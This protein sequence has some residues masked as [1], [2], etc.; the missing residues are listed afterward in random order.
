[1]TTARKAMKVGIAATPI[2]VASIAKPTPSEM[3]AGNNERAR[4]YNSAR[5]RKRR[6][7][8]LREHPLCKPCEDR[9]LVI[10][11]TV[12]DHV[13]GHQHAGWRDRFWDEARWQPL[14]A[15]CHAAKS[16]AELA[17]W[18]RTGQA[19]VEPGRGSRQK[20]EGRTHTACPPSKEFPA[21][22][23]KKNRSAPTVAAR[24]VATS[25]PA[26]RKKSAL[27]APPHLTAD[28]RKIW[29]QVVAHLEASG[30]AAA[31]IGP[32]VETYV[33]AVIRQRR[34]SAALA[35]A[36]LIDGDGKLHAA[37]RVLEATSA[38]VKN[39]AVT[40]G[41]ATPPKTRSAAPE[42]PREGKWAGVL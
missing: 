41:L 12:V 39:L 14:C 32:T 37:L 10:A 23:L 35:D 7:A 26:P 6:R 40:L 11:A 15:T 36:P 22:T 18:Q 42:R 24:L 13:D 28:G 30:T 27:P 20:R 5:W 31:V 9:G 38:T 4:L 25:S 3:E 34:L 8:F 29:R 2:S 1:M 16:A 17:G 19:V 21:M 33:D